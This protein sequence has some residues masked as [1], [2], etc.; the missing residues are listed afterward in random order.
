MQSNLSL[1]KWLETSQAVY[2]NTLGV[3]LI[4]AII[5][6]K[7]IVQIGTTEEVIDGWHELVESGDLMPMGKAPIT[8]EVKYGFFTAFL[9]KHSL[10]SHISKIDGVK[11]TF[12]PIPS[13]INSI[14]RNALAQT[15]ITQLYSHQI[16]AWEAY[17]Q[18]RNIA[19]LT[20]TSS[21]KSLAFLIPALQ[22]CM[23]NKS[24]L[25]FFNLKGLALDQSRKIKEIVQHIPENIRP[26]VLNIN[27]DIP[28]RERLQQYANTPTIILATPDAWNHD[29][30]AS[31]GNNHQLIQTLLNIKLVIIDEMHLYNGTF[32]AHFAWLNKRM[33]LKI[34]MLGGNP[35]NIRY[36]FASATIGN[37]KR[38]ASLI[39]N[40][41][42]DDL[43][44]IE[45]SGAKSFE[46]QFV[47][48]RNS[49]T[50]T[51]DA[52]ICLAKLIELDVT[53]I[54]FAISRAQ[55][56]AIAAKARQIL[57]A[58]DRSDL[59]NKCSCFYGSMKPIQR[60]EIISD[61]LK[62]KIKGIVST[63]ALEAGVDISNISATIICKYPGTILSTRQQMGRAGRHGEGLIVF[64][65]SQQSVIDGYYADNPDKLFTDKAEIISFNQNYE[66]IVTNHLIAAAVESKPTVELIEEY[67]GAFGLEIM[68]KLLDEEKL[69]PSFNNRIEANSNLGYY[70]ANIKMRGEGGNIE[71]INQETGEEFE[72]SSK[73]IA[74][75]E[76]YQ[77]A[78]YPAQDFDGHPVKYRAISLDLEEGNCI[79]KPISKNTTLYTVCKAELK[80]SNIKAGK[81]ERIHVKLTEDSFLILNPIWGSLK[82]SVSGYELRN[83]E[84]RWTCNRK[85]CR[86]H[87]KAIYTGYKMCPACSN[88]LRNIE[89]DELIED[90]NYQNPITVEYETPTIEVSVTG[91]ATSYFKGVV[92]NTRQAI[93]EDI[94]LGK[95][96]MSREL[97]KVFTCEPMLLVIHTL[98]HQLMLALPLVKHETNS[99]D[100]EFSLTQNQNSIIG[101][102][103]DTI[104]NGTGACN[105]LLDYW[106]QVVQ[107]ARTLVNNCDC[108]HGCHR[109]TTM[110]Q[111]PDDNE[112]LFKDLGV[113]LLQ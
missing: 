58:R 30:E 79:L 21:G 81:G 85:K 106:E 7:L 12:S 22:E 53:T 78:I 11:G 46:K 105:T 42:Q 8:N 92:L 71:Y 84:L 107:K 68:Q 47:C 109:C 83:K 103:F 69:L 75:R 80:I 52:A 9:N 86:N 110:H 87:H 65:P 57:I 25:I 35:H 60:S 32:G 20:Q 88:L 61:L 62:E 113:K 29:L 26:K 36:I 63:S 33:Q 70:H 34:D 43:A 2:I 54:C 1:P 18:N 31:K 99:K 89:V 76:V 15:G 45:S 97:A 90:V 4:K 23:E 38:I 96:T 59:A 41:S 16:E 64:I 74:I 37:P 101:Y 3:G 6:K 66:S 93:Q 112:H 95:R 13:N 50:S 98:A 28:R 67:F 111:C 49:K 27:G 17:K 44:I 51:Q 55:S 19:L 48:L 104:A 10:L 82:E 5:A 77:G 73:S 40:R 39:S 108:K 102:F 100:I 91:N 94:H 72:S 14:I 56:K 24:V